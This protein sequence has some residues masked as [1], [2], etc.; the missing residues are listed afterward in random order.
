MESIFEN[1]VQTIIFIDEIQKVYALKNPNFTDGKHVPAKKND[2]D[3]VTFVD[4]VLGLSREKN[5][6]LYVTGSNSKML[7]SD[8]VTEFRDKATN[9]CLAP[10]SFDEF[11]SQMIPRILVHL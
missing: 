6:D 9:I 4:V 1:C 11:F 10:L 5:I 3:T 7:S 8:I 2:D